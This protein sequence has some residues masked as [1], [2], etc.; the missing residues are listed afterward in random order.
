VLLLELT[1]PAYESLLS[2]LVL[3]GLKLTCELLTVTAGQL[4]KRYIKKGR[5]LLVVI[6][7]R[8]RRHSIRKS[9]LEVSGEVTAERCSR[10]ECRVEECGRLP[11]NVAQCFPHDARLACERCVRHKQIQRVGVRRMGVRRVR[12]R[13]GRSRG[14]RSRIFGGDLV[15]KRIVRSEGRMMRCVMDGWLRSGLR[16]LGF[17]SS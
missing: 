7:D 13:C 15:R 3:L 9:A 6:R 4:F 2:L 12:R 1:L 17:F 10:R 8:H 16:V 14:G 5:D 11:V